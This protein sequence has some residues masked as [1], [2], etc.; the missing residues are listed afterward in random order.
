MLSLDDARRLLAE[1]LHLLPA[2]HVELARAH[3]RF[4]RAPVATPEDLPPFD[5]SAFDGYALLS[6]REA[7][8]YAVA[9]EV[10]AGGVPNGPLAAAECARIF[11]GAPLPPGAD[12]V[13]MQEHC[14]RTEEGVR[15]PALRSGE[16][17]RRQGEDAR[18]GSV[19]V[20][21]GA[22]LGAVELSL[23][24]QVGHTRPLV[25]PRPRV[26][27]VR[28]GAEIV[29]P[30][31]EP[32]AGQIRDSNST[33]L[34]AL[35]AD[36]GAELKCRAT[37]GDELESLVA[38]CGE[39]DDWDLLLIS[40]GASVGD[41][42]FGRAALVE[43]G[44]SVRFAGLNLRPGKP[45]IFATRGRQVA[46]VIPGNPLSHLVCWHVIIRAALDFLMHGMSRMELQEVVVQ[47]EAL[48]GNPR[49]TWWPARVSISG[50]KAQ[51]EPLRWQSSG[52]MTGVAGINALLRVPANA[53]VIS[54]GD[55]VE[56][57]LL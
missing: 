3:G 14:E 53:A 10:A 36:A 18:A 13:A 40:G 49:E 15:I 28:T 32:G 11:T 27:H 20:P 16:G 31:A 17:V 5:R 25:A 39:G 4:L 9:Y 47:G 46:F 24:A 51:A 21:P 12:A 33:L 44:F 56:A 43:L 6:R 50:G 34:A 35:I 1:S 30:E 55:L 54:P 7:A 22:R 23:L 42:D 19:L 41:Y 2:E 29:P 8:V 38:A 26:F 52:D 37:C 45:L 48:K 57:L